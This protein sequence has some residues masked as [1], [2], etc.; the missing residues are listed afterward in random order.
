M[1][2]SPTPPSQSAHQS[3]PRNQWYVAA[4]SRE[5]GSGLLARTLLDAPV[6]LYRT[7][8]GR[9]VAL[10]D[11]CAHKGLPLS[12]GKLCG[13]SVQCGYHGIEFGPSGA[14][15][16]IPQQNFI[17]PSMRV[18]SFPLIEKWQ[19]IWIWMGD[20]AKADPALIPD[21][22]WLGLDREGYTAVPTFLMDI[23]ANYQLLHDNLLDNT[24]ISYM[25]AGLLDSGEVAGSTFS[26]EQAGQIV[27]LV[28]E[29]K[30]IVVNENAARYFRV[31]ANRRYDRLHATE[32]FAPSVNVGKNTYID[33]TDPNSRP[34]ELY[35]INAL[36]PATMRSTH[37]FN[38]LITSY[39]QQWSPEEI[40]GTRQINLQD[41][42]A[43]EA[44]QRRYDEFRDELEVSVRSDQAGILCRRIINALLQAEAAGHA[45]SADSRSV[46]RALG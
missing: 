7:P 12:M 31:E 34:V 14:C 20:P 9:A 24:H 39:G 25:H 16:K 45:Q 3:Y 22:Y 28:R 2:Q 30:D 46:E 1:Q 11:K 42:V 5:V 33:R 6:V 38:V 21:H 4:F 19:W 18:R 41:K 27:K 35:G 13:E 44:M 40:E 43:L 8:D 10:H 26:V 29:T 37:M 15:T 36:T 23:D 17:P 32:T